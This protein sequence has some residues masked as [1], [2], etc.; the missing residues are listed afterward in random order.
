MFVVPL[1]GMGV[2]RLQDRFRVRIAGVPLGHFNATSWQQFKVLAN[3]A[4]VPRLTFSQVP[5]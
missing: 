1:G 2:T 4:T 3:S 5:T